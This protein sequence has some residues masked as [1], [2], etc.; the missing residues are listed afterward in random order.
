MYGGVFFVV[1]I[2]VQFVILSCDY[3]FMY[4]LICQVLTHGV[5]IRLSLAFSMLF[6]EGRKY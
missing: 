3:H 6:D 5:H 1:P 2:C 4:F